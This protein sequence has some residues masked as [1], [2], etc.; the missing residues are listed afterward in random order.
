MYECTMAEGLGKMGLSAVVAMDRV[1]N[2]PNV[3]S[4]SLALYANQ[5]I[6]RKILNKISFLT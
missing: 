5:C 3:I 2:G 1:R 6:E 4:L